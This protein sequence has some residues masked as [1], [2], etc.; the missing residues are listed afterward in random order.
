M[1]CCV[2][3]L[4]RFV[5]ANVVGPEAW[6]PAAGH[7]GGNGCAL[8]L[9]CIGL[10]C[11][12]PCNDMAGCGTASLRTCCWTRRWYCLRLLYVAHPNKATTYHRVTTLTVT[13]YVI[14]EEVGCDIF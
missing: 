11:V 7:A 13:S 1:L 12:I 14:Q 10:I 3:V 5:C 9:P 8:Q 6:K 2:S 4:L